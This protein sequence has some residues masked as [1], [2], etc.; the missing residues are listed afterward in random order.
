[1]ICLNSVMLLITCT[2]TTF[3]Q[4]GIST[5]VVSSLEV[6]AMAGVARS[7]SLKRPRKPRPMSPS[8]EVMRTT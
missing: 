4:V 7:G 6:V 5:P 2:R 8:S 1:M 3:W